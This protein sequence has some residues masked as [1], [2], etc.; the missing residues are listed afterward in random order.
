MR[1]ACF[2]ISRPSILESKKIPRVCFFNMFPR[3]PFWV[4]SYCLNAKIVN[5]GTPSKS[6]RR[7][8]GIQ[9]RPND[10]KNSIYG[11]RKSVPGPDWRSNGSPEHPAAWFWTI[12]GLH[13]QP[14]RVYSAS[15][16][17][18]FSI[19]RV[20]F[21]SVPPSPSSSS[22]SL[23]SSKRSKAIAHKNW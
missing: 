5:L 12:L 19:R 1:N 13:W 7:Q 11:T 10:A 6:S 21:R 20:S 8:N 9:N 14:L 23:S 16:G 17:I 3:A 15:V 4:I 2:C 22:S 18:H